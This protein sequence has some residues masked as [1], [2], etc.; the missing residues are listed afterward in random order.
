MQ[1][2]TKIKRIY[3]PAAG[4]FVTSSLDGT[5]TTSIVHQ[6]LEPH[7]TNEMFA[8]TKH[9]NYMEILNALYDATLI[10]DINGKIIDGNMRVEYVFGYTVDE[11]FGNN[12]TQLI[13]G[14]TEELIEKVQEQVKNRTFTQIDCTCINKS[15]L[16]FP[17][18]MVA[19]GLGGGQPPRLCF[20]IRNAV[21]KRQ[22]ERELK[23]ANE[24]AIEAE[25]V[26]SRIDTI[27]TL[28]HNINNPLQIIS[29]MAEM[30]ANPEYKKQIDIIISV[31]DQ[32][33]RQQLLEEIIDENGASQYAIDVQRQLTATDENRILVV[34]D[35]KLV[36]EMFVL[37]LQ[38]Q[39]PDK[40]IDQSADGISAVDLFSEHKHSLI[41]MDSQMPK[42]SGE[43]AFLKIRDFCE[44]NSIEEPSCIFCTGF[45]V[46]DKMTEIIGD[47]ARHCFLKKP[48]RFSELS[49]AIEKVVPNMAVPQTTEP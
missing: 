10:T 13:V 31:L 41:L 15:G 24:M 20:F 37:G 46:S 21:A 9:T 40:T 3:D 26:Q 34:D 12:V 6:A 35:E 27:A 25:K 47:G 32:L 49:A 23:A 16:K 8:G 42:L 1:T 30:D 28:L 14:A 39:F 17:A 48:I 43:D 38:T 2:K 18:V 22:I 29:F 4:R 7:A 33:G 36:R 5:E 11:L 19:N 44:T 45:Q